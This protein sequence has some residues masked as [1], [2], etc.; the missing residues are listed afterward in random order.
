MSPKPKPAPIPMVK[1]SVR[2]LPAN[3]EITTQ[4]DDSTAP[5]TVTARQPHRFTKELDIGPEIIILTIND[6]K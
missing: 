2:T 1:I 4:A 3:A 5:A 6:E